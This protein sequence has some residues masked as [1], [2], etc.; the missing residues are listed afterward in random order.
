MFLEFD[1]FLC[2]FNKHIPTH[3]MKRIVN[4]TL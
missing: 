3:K 2:Q 1:I 4:L